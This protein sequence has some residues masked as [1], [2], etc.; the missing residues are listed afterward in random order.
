MNLLAEPLDRQLDRVKESIRD[1]PQTTTHRFALVSLMA[2]RGDYEHA[3]QQLQTLALL[4]KEFVMTAQ[5]LRMLIRAE[6]MREQTFSGFSRPL[7][8]G[9]PEPWLGVYLRALVEPAHRAAELR[10]SVIDQLPAIDGSADDQDFHWIC[11]GD[12]RLGPCF[13]LILDGQYYWLPA[14]QVSQ[15]EFSP[16]TVALDLVWAPIRVTLIN[17]GSQ[18]AYM[19]VRYPPGSTAVDDDAFLL[20]HRTEWD[21]VAPDSWHGRGR[22]TWIANGEDIPMFSVE[23]LKFSNEPYVVQ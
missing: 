19:P 14:D 4:D 2:L 16:P 23:T 17:G 11:D 1:Q 22:R 9:Q 13:E 20:G 12:S 6:R 21:E 15:L 3:L 10:H 5:M 18:P 8:L 7:I